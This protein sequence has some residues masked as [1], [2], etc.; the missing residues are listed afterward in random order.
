[1]ERPRAY[2]S[3]RYA[4]TNCISYFQGSG[5]KVM[6]KSCQLVLGDEVDQYQSPPN[7]NQIKEMEKRTRSYD[8]SIVGL[9]CTPTT[10]NGTI[11]QQYLTGSQGKWFLRCK[12]CNDL[13][14]DSSQTSN[15]Q[16]ESEYVEARRTYKVVKGSCR[17]ICPICGYQHTYDDCRWMNLNGGWVHKYPDLFDEC[18]SF[19]FGALASQL[20]ALNWDYI[21]QQQLEA[22]KTSDIELQMSF[23]NSI[24]GIAWKPRQ[25]QKADMDRFYEKHAWSTPPSLENVE[26]IGLSVDCMD[27][28]YSWGV[29][30]FDVNDNSYLI[31]CGETPYLELDE[32][33]RKQIN[34]D[35]KEAGKP[36]C[37]T[38][39]DILNKKY[40]MKDDVGLQPLICIIDQGGHKADEVKHF[41][42]FNKN[43]I[44]QKGTSMSS[45]N[46]KNSENQERLLIV[47]EK[48]FRSLAI[49]NLYSQ[50]SKTE[51]FF[52]MNPHIGEEYVKQIIGTKP[53]NTVK[54]GDLP[55]NWKDPSGNDHIFDV[56]KYWYLLKDFCLHSLNRKRYRFGQAP[57]LLRQ[58][59]KQI[60]K[61]NAD[62]DND[63][64]RSNWFKPL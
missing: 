45:A 35:L 12:G 27:D 31:D 17:L 57:S 1:M 48:F 28:F 60:K 19:Q 53:D 20:K 33:K 15:L 8:H 21:A 34:E 29:F 47:N 43:V 26:M 44:M 25:I 40:L 36:P 22:G 3:D 9:V 30:A 49:Y 4:F 41:A 51:N 61:E 32:A 16:F 63:V 56:V 52:F 58:W 50:K 62:K 23:D 37:Y 64:K 7:V 14:I 24:R 38:V 39:E 55:E 46:W 5:T 13:T 18:S 10:E 42:K 54:F 6:S 2:R 11:W 59:D